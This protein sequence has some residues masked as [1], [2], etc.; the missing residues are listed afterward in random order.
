VAASL[1][2]AASLVAV[3][4][5]IGSQDTLASTP[6]L[7]GWNWDAAVVGAEFD[8]GEDLPDRVG[9]SGVLHDRAIAALGVVEVSHATI[10][11]RYL[12]VLGFSDRRGSIGP[13][14]LRGRHPTRPSEAA[15]G[16]AT[17]RELGV[18][19]GERVTAPAPGGAVPLDV[20]GEVVVPSLGTDAIA[21]EGVVMTGAGAN[22]LT[23]TQ[24][25]DALL[26]R[27]TPGADRRA[28]EHRLA[29]IGDVVL[30]QPPADVVNLE[31]ISAIPRALAALL[32][33]LAVL[34]VG[35]ALTATVRRRRRD[36]AVLKAI[37]FRPRQL[38]STVVWQATLLV[39]AGLVVGVPLG[40]VVGR[41]SWTVVA[42]AMGLGNRPEAPLLVVAFTVPIA[43]AV[44]NVVALLPA[45]SAARTRPVAALRA[46]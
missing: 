28:V 8:S 4:V 9:S 19:I 38:S 6:S 33:G 31:R 15:L 16:R 30:D 46:E 18:S 3:V 26:V 20:V 2:G 44:A 34:A 43:I 41:V 21:D 13:T 14:V 17:M 29:E 40:V 1:A 39:A 42:D 11:G 12:H 25:S 5:F 32:G 22:R 37:G 36:L 7:Y 10:D 23:T 27:F 45:R 24:R 35:H